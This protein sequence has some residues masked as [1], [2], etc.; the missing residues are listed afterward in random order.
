M[1]LTLTIPDELV[2]QLR[3]AAEEQQLSV[4]ATVVLILRDALYRDDYF[5]TPE[6][7]V[8][9]IKGLPK[10]PM[11]PMPAQGSLLEHLRNSPTD[12]NF[13]LDAWNKEWKIVE[14]EMKAVT[15][16]NDMAEGRGSEE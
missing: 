10:N 9:K 2:Q 12:P 5:P 14:A 11:N 7:V 15:H 6:Q 3:Q 8:A 13:D 4:E 1:A 16:A